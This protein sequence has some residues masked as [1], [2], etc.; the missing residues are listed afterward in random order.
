MM[1]LKRRD[2]LVGSTQGSLVFGRFFYPV[3]RP[4]LPLGLGSGR[5]GHSCTVPNRTSS[6]QVW[7]TQ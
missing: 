5:P 4:G 1:L 7:Q 2:G 6:P 3:G